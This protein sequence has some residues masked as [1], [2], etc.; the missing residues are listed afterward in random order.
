MAEKFALEKRWPEVLAPLEVTQRWVMGLL[1]GSAWHEGRVPDRENL[2]NLTDHAL[3]VIDD[4]E[5]PRCV[6][7]AE[8]DGGRARGVQR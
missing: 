3:G 7:G 5:Y 8:S 2:E 1:L 4:A 6:A